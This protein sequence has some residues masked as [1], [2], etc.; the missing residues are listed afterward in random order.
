MNKVVVLKNIVYNNVEI[1]AVSG[2]ESFVNLE[3]IVDSIQKNDI[4]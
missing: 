4:L 2:T 3:K 1:D